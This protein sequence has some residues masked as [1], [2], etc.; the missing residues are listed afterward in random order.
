M[1]SPISENH[2]SSKQTEAPREARCAVALLGY[3]T[4]GRAV[5][6]MLRGGYL[7]LAVER[8]YRRPGK[9]KGDP[10]FT[11][12]FSSILDDPRIS[13]VIDVM[14]GAEPSRS[15]VAAALERGK[16]VVTA[17]KAAIGPVLDELAALAREK[18]AALGIEASCGGAI[19]WIANIARVR[20]IEPISAFFGILN[21][22]GNFIL[23]EVAAGKSFSAALA[24]AQKAG[25]AE[26]DPSAD[27]DGFDLAAKAQISAAA[28]FGVLVPQTRIPRATLRGIT[29]AF[30]QD[31]EALGFALRFMV[32]GRMTEAGPA[33]GVFPALVPQSR[34]E[35]R[36]TKNFNCASLVC[37]GAGELVFA[38]AGA[39]GR[40]TADAV[41][42]DA[43]A[44]ARGVI[45]PLPPIVRLAENECTAEI[46]GDAYFATPDGS[47]ERTAMRETTAAEA[48]EAARRR[49][50][51][52]AF[53]PKGF[54][55]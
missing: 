20:E 36:I 35:S 51:F 18:H 43:A 28:A 45:K 6:D 27:L 5:D 54:F 46:I 38:G 14:A 8:I 2:P 39:G 11:D 37:P 47:M 21:G 32:F 26:A 50:V 24:D 33:L 55:D 10:R 25:Y 29:S 1:E 9:T 13:I 7:G 15:A 17:N 48:A 30:I 16:S 12:D 22:T 53:A 41:V 23:G 31:A 44:V 42:N 3:G 40:P 19:P 34:L 4:V 49:G 52:M